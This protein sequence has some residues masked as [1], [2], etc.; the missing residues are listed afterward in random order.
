MVL[1][2]WL[3]CVCVHG[4]SICPGVPM[5]LCMASL[6][7]DAKVKALTSRGVPIA[8]D[9]TIWLPPKP[10][11]L[12]PCWASPGMVHERPDHIQALVEGALKMHSSDSSSSSRKHGGEKKKK[13]GAAKIQGRPQLQL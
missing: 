12:R 7:K 8:I 11:Q 1:R 10:E 9:K 13:K 3:V 6:A 4:G 5:Q 2:W